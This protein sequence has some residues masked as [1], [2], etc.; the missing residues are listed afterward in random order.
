MQGNDIYNIQS[1]IGKR[2]NALMFEHD[3]KSVLRGPFRKILDPFTV[4]ARN[5][6][7]L[8]RRLA[9]FEAAPSPGQLP[10]L[11]ADALKC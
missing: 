1:G 6:P 8:G 7:A 9:R 2:N 4:K 10:G 11:I 3:Q 5:L